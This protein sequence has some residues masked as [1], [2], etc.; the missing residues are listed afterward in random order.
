MKTCINLQEPRF[1]NTV[2]PDLPLPGL[3]CRAKTYLACIRLDPLFI[4]NFYILFIKD[5]CIDF[6][7]FKCVILKY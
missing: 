5:F 6:D 3:G 2:G 7:V 1:I 4:Y